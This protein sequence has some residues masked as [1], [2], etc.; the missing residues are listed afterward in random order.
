MSLYMTRDVSFL[1]KKSREF[2]VTFRWIAQL[3]AANYRYLRYHG[4]ED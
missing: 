2:R 1:Q 4:G 3:T